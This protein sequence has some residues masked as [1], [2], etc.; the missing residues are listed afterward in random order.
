MNEK[1][2]ENK[3]IGY[4]LELLKI[5]ND[6]NNSDISPYVLKGIFI[7]LLNLDKKETLKIIQE[8]KLERDFKNI[9]I[10]G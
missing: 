5:V 6:T 1:L 10:F 8:Y 7:E 9:N 3:L 2:N 4:I